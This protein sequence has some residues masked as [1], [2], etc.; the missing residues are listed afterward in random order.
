MQDQDAAVLSN[1]YPG[2]PQYCYR[3]Q[4]PVDT[5][6][7]SVCQQ[8]LQEA[9][10]SPDSIKHGRREVYKQDTVIRIYCR[11]ADS[12]FIVYS[13]NNIQAEDHKADGDHG[14]LSIY[15]PAVQYR[16]VLIFRICIGRQ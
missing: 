2:V 12:V 11:L 8:H 3:N 6:E 5:A 7:Q 10:D 9:E 15:I 16:L 4:P 1:Q 14:L 13:R